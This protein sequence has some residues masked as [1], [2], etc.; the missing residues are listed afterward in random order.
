MAVLRKEKH[1]YTESSKH[2]T[3]HKSMG[4]DYGVQKIE[5]NFSGVKH[6]AQPNFGFGFGLGWIWVRIGFGIGLMFGF[7]LKWSYGLFF[8]ALKGSGRAK[9]STDRTE[10]MAR[11]GSINQLGP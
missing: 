11:M 10:G 4:R 2:V 8:L 3:V 9:E 6:W 7:G 1:I 5:Q